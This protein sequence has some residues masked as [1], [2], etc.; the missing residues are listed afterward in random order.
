MSGKERRKQLLIILQTANEPLT[1]IVLARQLGVS[2]QVIVG[3]M[4][5]LRAMGIDIYATP[6]GYLILANKISSVVTVKLACRHGHGEM[7]EEL[8]TI[9]EH[10][11][12]VLDVIVE[13]GVYGEIKA[14]LMIGSRHDLDAFLVSIE[15]SGAEPLSTITSGIHLHTVEAPSV[16]VIEIIKKRLKEQHILL[17]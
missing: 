17:G 2:R 1:G 9:I 7:A 8:R 4:A 5:I 14:N 10:G 12:K 6:Q 13:H 3:D 11:G 16:E 15:A